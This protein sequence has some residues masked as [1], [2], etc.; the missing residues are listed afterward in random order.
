MARHRRAMSAGIAGTD[1][2]RQ[3]PMTKK[4]QSC[5]QNKPETSRH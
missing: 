3:Q 4:D 1:E 5:S 2:A